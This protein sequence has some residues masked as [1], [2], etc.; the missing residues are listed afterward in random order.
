MDTP[1]RSILGR[2]LFSLFTAAQ[3]LKA[4]GNDSLSNFKAER[5]VHCFQSLFLC[6]DVSLDLRYHRR[7]LFLTFLA[8][9]GVYVMSFSLSISI[10]WTISAFEE[11]VVYHR[12]TACAGSAVFG[13]VRLEIGWE[14]IYPCLFLSPR[15][16]GFCWGQLLPAANLAVYLCGCLPLHGIGDMAVDIDCCFG[17]NMPYCRRERFHVHSVFKCHRRECVSEVMKYYFGASCPLQ[18]N[19]QSLADC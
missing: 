16:F 14:G 8:C 6:L 3:F 5:F 17:R 10:S 18:H 15:N 13:L 4:L 7:R 12:H 11:V 1:T 2:V 9:F 19:L